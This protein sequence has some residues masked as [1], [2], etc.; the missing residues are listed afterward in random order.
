[1]NTFIVL[2]LSA[3]RVLPYFRRISTDETG[4]E[5]P[6]CE[7]IVEWCLLFCS[8]YFIASTK[9][10]TPESHWSDLGRTLGFGVFKD[11]KEIIWSSFNEPWELSGDSSGWVHLLVEDQSSSIREGPLQPST[12]FREAHGAVREEEDTHQISQISP[13]TDATHLQL[14]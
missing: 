5:K 13:M 7:S 14:C 8:C 11:P 3:E 6:G 1:M 10:N 2:L 12:Q 9:N 4:W